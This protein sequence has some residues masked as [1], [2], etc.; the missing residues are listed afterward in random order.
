MGFIDFP[1]LVVVFKT[2]TTT[3]IIP[4]KQI[5]GPTM[6]PVVVEA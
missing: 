2:T 3:N 6:D 1:P 4:V 5:R